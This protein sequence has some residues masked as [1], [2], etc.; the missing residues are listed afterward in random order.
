[1]KKIVISFDGTCNEPEDAEQERGF[2]GLGSLEDDSITN[3][4]KLHL[5]LGG[6]LK[7]SS[8][9][10]D[11]LC[12]Y[13][14]GVGTYGGKIQRAFNAGLAL[15]RLD[16][17]HIMLAATR[18]LRAVYEHGDEVFVFGFSR[19]SALARQFASLLQTDF[20]H[21]TPRIKFLGVFDTVASIG[22]P[23]LN[24]K[25]K[26]VSDVVFED[27]TIAPTIEQALH[28]VAIDEKRKAFMPTLMNKEDRVMEV[29]FPGAHSDVGGGNR[30]DGLSDLTLEFMLEE[31]DRRQLGLKITHPGEILYGS[32]LPANAE[33]KID[34]SDVMI[35]PKFWG[36]NHEQKRVFTGWL[37][38]EDRDLR[39]N[40]DDRPSDDLPLLHYSVAERIHGD[41]DYRP[42]SLIGVSHRMLMPDGG[43]EIYGGLMAHRAR[44]A[45]PI[46][47]LEPGESKRVKVYARKK[48]NPGGALMLRGATYVFEFDQNQKWYDA[49]IEATVSGWSVEEEDIGFIKALGINAAGHF[50]RVTD[51]RWFEL[52]AAV[53]QSEDELFPVTEFTDP[54]HPYEAQRNGEF[55]PFANDLDSRYGN[56]LGY[57]DVTIK[58][59]S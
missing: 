8:A 48:Y 27:H 30:R 51:S 41:D 52:V 9:F 18:A 56:N 36:V 44:S 16:A 35:N 11:Q 23:N 58:R 28:I 45:L 38:L 34:Y 42:D 7:G 31:L 32:L 33:F 57:V 59:V 46:S 39:V 49:S 15:Q 24:D 2:F 14:S 20:P 37:T 55:C 5:M 3:V 1:M 43:A 10:E 19:G 53:G 47:V 21:D 26:P 29:W 50:R 25:D 13:F 6:D 17:D 54:A 22:I 12:F 40:V 4:L